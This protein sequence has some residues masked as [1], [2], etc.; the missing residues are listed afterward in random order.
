MLDSR[1]VGYWS[2][3]PLYQGDM[4]FA[5][6]AFRADWTGWTYWCNAAGAFEVVRFS[7][8][9]NG[10]VLHLHLREYVA[11][12]WSL[13]GGKLT[14]QLTDRSG[15]DQ[16]IS[17]AYEIIAGQNAT[18]DPATLLQFDQSVIRGVVG[19]RFALKRELAINERDPGYDS[20]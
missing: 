5:D 4:E 1:L 16:L 20:E 3:E 18:G 12:T 17:L 9:G 6:V 10:P 2:D 14:H 7:W 11:G 13:N 8:Q 19:D 15:E